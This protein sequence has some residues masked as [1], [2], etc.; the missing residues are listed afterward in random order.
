MPQGRILRP[1]LCNVH[2]NDIVN[3]SLDDRYVIR[4]DHTTVFLGSYVVGELVNKAII[5]SRGG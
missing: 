1:M 3:L 5:L 2:T 4:A